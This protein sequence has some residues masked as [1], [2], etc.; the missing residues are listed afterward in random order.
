MEKKRRN[1]MELEYSYCLISEVE[2]KLPDDEFIKYLAK[3]EENP[4]REPHN[5]YKIEIP[6]NSNTTTFNGGFVVEEEQASLELGIP[7]SNSSSASTNSNEPTTIGGR[8]SH[9]QADPPLD[10]FE[11]LL[12]T[13]NAANPLTE[14]LKD[15]EF[16]F[17]GCKE[18]I[19]L[20]SVNPDTFIP[21]D[22]LN[23]RIG[24]NADPEVRKKLYALDWLT[25]L[26]NT[27]TFDHVPQKTT[28][29]SGE[30]VD[31][32]RVSQEKSGFKAIFDGSHLL[33][34]D[35]VGAVKS[36]SAAKFISQLLLPTGD[37][38]P[39]NYGKPKDLVKYIF[40][41]W[42]DAVALANEDDTGIWYTTIQAAIHTAEQTL[43]KVKRKIVPPKDNI[44]QRDVVLLGCH[45]QG[46]YNVY[47]SQDHHREMLSMKKIEPE[48][49]DII[50]VSNL[51]QRTSKF[52]S[53]FKKHTKDINKDIT[54]DER[55]K[56]ETRITQPYISLALQWPRCE[57]QNAVMDGHSAVSVAQG[58]W[59]FECKR[60]AEW[61]HR[62][63]YS[64]GG[65]C[66]N[67]R[68]FGN[69]DFSQT[70]GN[71]VFGTYE[72]NTAMIRYESYLKRLA[73]ANRDV[74]LVTK[75]SC[76][77]EGYPPWIAHRLHY[78]W[79]FNWKV[80]VQTEVTRTYTFN[81]FTMRNPSLFEVKVDEG[82]DGLWR[83]RS[84]KQ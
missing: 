5:A 31:E 38:K 77:E 69:P 13:Y 75:T 36:G 41:R 39:E 55:V 48:K 78:T 74:T 62:S 25:F 51:E 76:G 37:D 46:F 43:D 59:K 67:E 73:Q 1:R 61:L 63:A 56:T 21:L 9:P 52:S 23:D 81:L 11:Y 57:T 71:L 40:K 18:D 2:E 47:I 68:K 65:L 50:V 54:P 19:R 66:N 22:A 17:S 26:T 58:L 44:I 14:D 16:I 60:S 15:T 6:L 3:V 64:F 33:T 12:F 28:K 27:P 10:P 72:S 8:V 24:R 7:C 29:I 35:N 32:W 4:I 83:T 20:P 84:L 34:S 82:F 49:N 42:Q 45:P 80:E 79:Q 70:P 53:E 30:T